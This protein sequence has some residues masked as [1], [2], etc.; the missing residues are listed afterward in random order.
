MLDGSAVSF[1]PAADLAD[2]VFEATALRTFTT[3][4]VPPLLQLPDYAHFAVRVDDPYRAALQAAVRDSWSS[5]LCDKDPLNVQAVFPESVL[6]PVVSGPQVMKAQLL[7]LME[8]S[9]LDLIEQCAQ[10]FEK[11]HQTA[12]PEG[13][14]LELIAEAIAEL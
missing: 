14:S 6:R 5:R 12:L 3:D 4:F 10:R 13:E 1:D 9:E 7:H 8:M 11:L 2:L